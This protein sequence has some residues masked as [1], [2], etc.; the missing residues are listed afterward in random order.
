VNAGLYNNNKN[1]DIRLSFDQG[2]SSLFIS[3]NGVGIPKSDQ[4]KVFEPFVRLTQSVRQSGTGLGLA[5]CKRIMQLHDGDL[6]LAESNT[7]GS[8][9]KLRLKS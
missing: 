8:V 9:W 3:D 1:I 4:E 7:Q 5:I 2:S 6:T